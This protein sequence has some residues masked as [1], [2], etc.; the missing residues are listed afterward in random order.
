MQSKRLFLFLI[1]FFIVTCLTFVSTETEIEKKRT[2]PKSAPIAIIGPPPL[3][4]G[5]NSEFST[6]I[7]FSK[8]KESV[9]P[10]A[11]IAIKD[12]F[13]RARKFGRIYSAKIISWGDQL[14]SPQKKQRMNRFQLKL[15]EDRNDELEAYLEGLDL[16]LNVSKISMAEKPDVMDD[17][18]SKD[19]RE[20]KKQ[21]EYHDVTNASK[22]IVMFMIKKYK[23]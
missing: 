16:Q 9:S 15:V 7:L 4:P 12:L 2:T 22:S 11:R 3:A 23:K 5:F 13:E 14:R 20:L 17:L 18:L 19:D 6:E 8:G 1:F 21:L 10:S